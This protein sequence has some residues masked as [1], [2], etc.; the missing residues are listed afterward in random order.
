LVLRPA[1]IVSDVALILSHVAAVAEDVAQLRIRPLLTDYRGALIGA[2][3]RTIVKRAVD[4]EVTHVMTDFA[5][6]QMDVAPIPGY[7]AGVA[8]DVAAI[9][10]DVPDLPDIDTPVALSAAPGC[11]RRCKSDNLSA[12]RNGG[13]GKGRGRCCGN[14]SVPHVNPP[15]RSVKAPLHARS[16]E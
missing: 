8:M 7:V 9:V 3:R 6:V 2:D 4:A 1:T 12:S 11:V 5:T 14:Q 16:R 15:S 13:Y 10:P